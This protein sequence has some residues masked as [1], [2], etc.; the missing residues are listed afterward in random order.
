MVMP[1]RIKERAKRRTREIFLERDVS[2]QI[3]GGGTR[4][5]VPFGGHV[6]FEDNWNRESDEKEIC[7]NVAGPHGHELSCPLPTLGS[8]IGDDLPVVNE[9]LTLGEGCD[10]HGDERHDQEPADALQTDFV[11]L[12]P[13]LAGETL[14]EFGDGEFGYPYTVWMML[15]VVNSDPRHPW[16]HR[17]THNM[18]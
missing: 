12:P 2:T 15:S 11:G 14:E 9:G 3:S 16:W 13:D 1:T 8:W 10:D 17:A 18:A 5:M 7:N 6:R 4:P